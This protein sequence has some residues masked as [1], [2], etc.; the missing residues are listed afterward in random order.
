MLIACFAQ[1]AR[2]ASHNRLCQ[3]LGEKGREHHIELRHRLRSWS[4]T[5]ASA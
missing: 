5:F 2:R 1:V 4:A 3:Y